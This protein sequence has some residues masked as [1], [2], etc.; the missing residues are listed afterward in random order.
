MLAV[1]L[2]AEPHWPELPVRSDAVDPFQPCNSLPLLI[3]LLLAVEW[4]TPLNFRP[5]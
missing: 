3:G 5:F 4:F 2:C 1:R